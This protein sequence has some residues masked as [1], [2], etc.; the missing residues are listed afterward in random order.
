MFV[1]YTYK[2]K[3]IIYAIRNRITGMMYIGSSFIPS[4]RFHQHLI[5]KTNSNF[6]LQQ[7][8]S[9]YGL[10]N[11][12]VYILEVVDFPSTLLYN[13]RSKFLRKR[14]QFFINQYPT[15]QLFNSINSSAI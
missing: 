4:A 1:R 7:S 11:F 10:D 5:S 8:I 3:P 15:V 13:E 14:E 9:K 6:E 12:T 2:N